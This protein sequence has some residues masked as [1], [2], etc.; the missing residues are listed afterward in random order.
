MFR[1][2]CGGGWQLGPYDRLPSGRLHRHSTGF[3]TREGGFVKPLQALSVLQ[4][5]GGLPVVS[6]C[7]RKVS[8]ILALYPTRLRSRPS[9]EAVRDPRCRVWAPSPPLDGAHG[10]VG[11]RASEGFT[12]VEQGDDPCKCNRMNRPL[13][14]FARG[15]RLLWALRNRGR[16]DSPHRQLMLKTPASPGRELTP[17]GE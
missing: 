2:S 9:P 3:C 11:P 7:S 12:A 15:R 10:R 13:E 4:D 8:R 5:S 17:S 1:L 6:E 16:A 14:V